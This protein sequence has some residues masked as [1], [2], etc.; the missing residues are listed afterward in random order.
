MGRSGN[1]ACIAA[2]ASPYYYDFLDLTGLCQLQRS[3]HVASMYHF[4]SPPEVASENQK[5]NR[6][7][8]QEKMG[9]IKF[10]DAFKGF[11]QA[12]LV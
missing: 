6:R 2:A 7:K 10:L 3:D 8:R 1:A 9:Q 4:P 5:P 11:L 12:S